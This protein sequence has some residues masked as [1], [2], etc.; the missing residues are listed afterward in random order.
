MENQNS[1]LIRGQCED[2]RVGR[3]VQ[4]RGLRALKIRGWFKTQNTAN[5]RRI[6]VVVC[7]E[8]KH[9]GI[10]NVYEISGGL[11]VSSPP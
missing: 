11:S 5:D 1:P 4:L 2:L 7:L 3:S 6:Q 8:P 9:T 10:L